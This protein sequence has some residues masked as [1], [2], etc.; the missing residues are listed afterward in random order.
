MGVRAQW[1]VRP[2]AHFELALRVQ[3]GDASLGEVFAFCSGLYFR[4]KLAY[5]TRFARVPSLLSGAQVITPSRGLVPAETRIGLKEL[6]EFSTVPVDAAEPRFTAP[7]QATAGALPL[8]EPFEVVILGSIATGKYVETL[9][10]VFGERLF[11]PADFVGRG[12][13]SRGALMLSCAASGEELRYVP[14]NGT[15]RKG[16]RAPKVSSMAASRLR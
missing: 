16:R 7:L 2:Q 13:M 11:F 12:D 9:L 4:G 5:A 3:I 6:L 1:L 15:I 8:S 14:V 10:P